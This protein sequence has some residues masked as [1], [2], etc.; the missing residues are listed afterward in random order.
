[1]DGLGLAMFIPLLQ[2]VDETNAKADSANMGNLSFLAD[3]LNSMGIPLTLVVV[4][5]I[6]LIFFSLKGIMKFSEAYSRVIF[7]Q[8]FIKNIRTRNIKGLAN[9]N[10]NVF[11]NSDI[12]RIQNTFSAEVERVKQAYRYY[13]IS[14]QYAVFVMVYVFM[15]LF[16][17]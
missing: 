11:I 6:I 14:I 10:F 5:V 8:L 9:F 16:E 2:M 17:D 15:A 13:F 7:E 12:G 1:M 4:L 3:V